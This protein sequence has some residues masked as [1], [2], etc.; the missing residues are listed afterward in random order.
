MIKRDCYDVLGVT[1]NA[2][3]EE[4]KRA[5]RRLALQYHPDRN[6]GNSDFEE[7][8]KEAAEAYSVLGDP[9][10]R[11]TYDRYGWDGLRG[12]GFTG[13]PGF[14][15]SIFGD[16][17]DILGSLFGFGDLFGA[18]TG[19]RRSYPQRGRDLALELEI[20]LE[21][22]AAGVEREISLNRSE[23]C[24]ACHGSGMEAGTKREACPTCGGRGQ[25]R[26]Q[27]GFFTIS[28][29][30]SHCHGKGEIVTSPCPDCRGSG[31]VKRR[32]SLTVKIP[33][34]IEDGSRLRLEGQGEAGDPAAAPGDLL[35]LVRVAKHPFFEREGRN[36]FCQLD[37]SFS[38]AALGA[39]VDVPG[40]DGETTALKV[41]AGTQTGVVFRQK[42]RG[43]KDLQTH[44]R[45]DLYV[46]VRV[47][48][49]EN[50]GQEEKTLLRRLAE[51]RGEDLSTADRSLIEK[52]KNVIH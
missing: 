23:H 50:L 45:G 49:P 26:Y 36:L 28:R 4:I 10:K 46:K 16:F 25:M 13:F 9:A 1:R 41:P 11:A 21:E 3:A 42:G 44:R 20:S 52:L 48:T 31:R 43:I 51:L 27:Q 14:D 47:K 19:R 15:A 6:P 34:G 22:A 39:T 7:K 24:P 17:E 33:G 12:E 5:Y 8:F 32:Q 35:V 37:I 30:C 40:L 29:P 38:Q 2:S 18:R